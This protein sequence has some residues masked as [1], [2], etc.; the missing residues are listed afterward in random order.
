MPLNRSPPPRSSSTSTLSLCQNERII[1]QDSDTASEIM[2]SDVEKGCPNTA[3]RPKRKHGDVANAELKELLCD[4]QR[5]QEEEFRFI[6]QDMEAIKQQNIESQR[7]SEKSL[8][9]LSNMYD[10]LLQKFEAV[11]KEN[12]VH[13]KNIHLLEAKVEQLERNIKSSSIEVRNIPLSKS[14][15]KQDLK[16]HIICL[17]EAINQPIQDGEIRYIFRV[18]TKKEPG[19]VIVEFTTIL[20]KENFIKS[21][22]GFN[23]DKTKAEKLNTAHL[24]IHGN[25]NPVYVTDNLTTKT[26]R[27]YYLTREFTKAHPQASCW[28]TFGKIYI[29]IGEGLPSIH[30]STEEDLAKLK[31]QK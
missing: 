18:K 14:E 30:I 9:F 17:G 25:P 6:K 4:I 2:Q 5:K 3:R 26:R 31:T 24:K 16:T 20:R 22:I 8:E 21:V 13:R 19:P 7:E 11:V 27:L 15:T 12:S 29:R 28:I 10:A 1:T 23:K